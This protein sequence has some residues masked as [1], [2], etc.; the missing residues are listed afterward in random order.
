MEKNDVLKVISE[1]ISEGV[2]IVNDRQEI[3]LCNTT[4]NKMFGY[5]DEE[6]VGRPLDVLILEGLRERHGHEVKEFMDKG[7]ARPMGPGLE[8]F[9]MRKNHQRFPVEISLNPFNLEGEKYVMALVVDIT[10][11]KKAEQT[12]DYWFQIFDESLN[13]IYVF[14]AETF[15]FINVN[16]GAQ[17]NLGYNLEE[18]NRLSVFDIK[19]KL[20]KEVMKRLVS[21]LISG[22]KEKVN[23]ETVH[24]RKD[25]SLYPVEVHL[26]LSHIG[27]RKVCVAIVLDITER[28]YYTQ[29]FENTVDDR[30]QQLRAALMS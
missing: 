28:T 27:K 24:K 22:K 23:F 20:S 19:P 25:G 10:E 4:A 18:L 14:D 5:Q 8:L 29:Q 21:P 13:E 11:R 2:V 15:V 1:V 17:L 6:L 30:T 26:Q 3:V 7:K 12:I 9:G 16:R